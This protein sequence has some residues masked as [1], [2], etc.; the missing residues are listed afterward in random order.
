MS[1][2][3]SSCGAGSW[4]GTMG[5]LHD[6]FLTEAWR[7]ETPEALTA[8]FGHALNAAGIPVW[9]IQVGLR[10]LHPQLIGENYTWRRDGDGI[11]TSR[12]TR[13][14]VRSEMF[15]H[16]PLAPIF[17]GAGAV[18][19]RLL[20]EHADPDYP[21]LRELA[22]AG[23]TDYVAFPMAFPD[24]QMNAITF[25]TRARSGFGT[26]GLAAIGESLGLLGRLYE[27]HIQ[28][29]N[30]RTLLETYLGRRSG[31]RVL[32]GSVHR[33]DGEDIEAAIWL[34]DL[35]DSTTMIER[36]PRPLYLDMLNVFFDATAGSVAG[37]GGEVLKF[38]GDAVLAIFPVEGD[39]ADACGR[40]LTA[41]R[42]A[43]AR[44]DGINEHR[45]AGRPVLRAA[46][47][48]HIGSV[49]FGNVGTG[50]RLDFTATG[51]AVN[52]TT[53]LAEVCKRYDRPLLA[54]GGFAA[55]GKGG[56]VPFDRI[57]LRG[58][59]GEMEVYAPA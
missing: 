3:E 28:R 45:D 14:T 8:A 20:G 27:A 54:S 58:S 52:Q 5:G 46:L 15:L 37:R 12:T 30:A 31:G 26:A 40:A 47:A 49:A 24:G 22:A 1:S 59:S 39:G 53:R 43:L 2:D 50:D 32:E 36:L 25:A 44:L 51:P 56:L 57:G 38:I 10:T 6:W 9:R 41:A 34:A 29:S 55:L 7:A 35:R 13:E 33:G 21:I 4:D 19:R 42:D 18:R 48:L 17:A 11:R 16:S 23:A